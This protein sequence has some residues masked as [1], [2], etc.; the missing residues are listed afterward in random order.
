MAEITQQIAAFKIYKRNIK[1]VFSE[2]AVW[3]HIITSI[4]WNPAVHQ[5]ATKAHS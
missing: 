4:I 2:D 1:F 3:H 5:Q